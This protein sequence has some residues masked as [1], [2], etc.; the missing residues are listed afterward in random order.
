MPT[1]KLIVISPRFDA[2]LRSEV[3]VLGSVTWLWMNSVN[4]Q[5][6]PLHDLRSIVLP[7]IETQQYILAVEQKGTEVK[8]IA[9]TSWANFDAEAEANYIQNAAM[10][11]STHARQSGDRMWMLDWLTP[12]GHSRPFMAI[13]RNLLGPNSVRT[14]Y[15]R[16]HERGMRVMH[17]HG[18]A[19]SASQAQQWWQSRPIQLTKTPASI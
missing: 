13:V 11:I 19:T 15:H 14:L 4:H 16:G 2:P 10:S 3:E 18:D 1:S 6:M 5:S 9:Y 12:F 7:A 8:P 17:L